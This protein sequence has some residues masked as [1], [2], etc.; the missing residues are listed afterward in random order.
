MTGSL[1]QSKIRTGTRSNRDRGAIGVI[2]SGTDA[3]GTPRAIL[4]V[5]PE[6]EGSRRERLHPGDKFTFGDEVW[7]LTDIDHPG[8]PRAWVTITRVS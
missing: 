7:E 6:A 3:D 4:S 8:D 2:S 1:P 5:R